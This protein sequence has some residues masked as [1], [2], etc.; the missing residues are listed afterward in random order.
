M[1]GRKRDRKQLFEKTLQEFLRVFPN[2]DTTETIQ[3][4]PKGLRFLLELERRRA[5]RDR[6]ANLSQREMEQLKVWC[7]GSG[8]RFAEPGPLGGFAIH[9]CSDPVLS[10]LLADAEKAARELAREL[11]VM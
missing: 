7:G 9:D 1:F 2:A 10:N 8:S 3:D 11:G 5:A 4:W 6:Q